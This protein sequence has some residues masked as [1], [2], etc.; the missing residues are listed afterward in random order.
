[1]PAPLHLFPF[2]LSASYFQTINEQIQQIA[3]FFLLQED[4]FNI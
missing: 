2:S 3:E 1:M 4:I